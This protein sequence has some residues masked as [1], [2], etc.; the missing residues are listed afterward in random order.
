MASSKYLLK[1]RICLDDLQKKIKKKTVEQA[2]SELDI[3]VVDFGVVVDD[4]E[5]AGKSSF[6]PAFCRESEDDADKVT[7]EDDDDNEA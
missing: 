4:V 3:I 5:F 6:Q 2:E 1:K 7:C